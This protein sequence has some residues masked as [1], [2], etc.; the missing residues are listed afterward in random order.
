MYFI[1]KNIDNIS[2]SPNITSVKFKLDNLEAIEYNSDNLNSIDILGIRVYIISFSEEF[3]TIE[4]I[5]MALMGSSKNIS[6]S[7]INLSK[8][9]KTL[10]MLDGDD[11]LEDYT[12]FLTPIQLN[13]LTGCYLKFAH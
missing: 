10:I 3:D 4:G 9:Y 7:G 8:H 5:K 11:N 13:I 1:P 2:T 12:M 6:C